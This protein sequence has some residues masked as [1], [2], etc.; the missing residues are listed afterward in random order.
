MRLATYTLA[1]LGCVLATPLAASQTTQ[2]VS[3]DITTN[4]TWTSD[5]IWQL[6]GLVYVRPN[7]TLT[8]EEGTTVVGQAQP[9]TGTG[10]LASGLVVMVDGNIEAEGTAEAPIIFTAESAL[11]GE[12]DEN[13]RGLW[14]GVIILG[15][16]TTNSTPA[17]NNVE[18]VPTSNDTRFGCQDGVS[19]F[20]CDEGDDSGT[21]RYVSIRHGGFGFEQDSEINGL[22]MGAVGSGTTIEYVEVFANS[23]DAFEWFGG[24]V[25]SKYLAGAF[26]GDD[27]FDTDRGFRGKI[28]FGFSINNPGNDAGRCLENDGGTSALGGEDATPF[29]NPIYSN[30][31]CFGAGEDADDSVLGE[32]SN[33]AALQLRDNTG[34]KIF[35]SIFANYP[36]SAINIEALS[37][38]AEDTENRLDDN[39][40]TDDLSIRNNYFF[41]FDAGDTFAAIIDDDDDNSATRQQEIESVLGAANTIGDPGIVSYGFENFDPRPT[42]TA[43]AASAADFSF[44]ALND[45]NDDDFFTEVDY[46]GAFAPIGTD[47]GDDQ[48]DRDDAVWLSE[49]TALD[50]MGYLDFRA[51]PNEGGPVAEALAL[52]VGPN[53]TAGDAT[54][55]FA[56]DRAQDARLALYDVLGREVAVVADGTFGAG[57]QTARLSTESLPA[58][59]YVLRLQAE[60]AATSVQ[61]SVVR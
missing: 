35:N 58:G 45:D 24:T 29:S 3:D 21:L 43:A 50:M 46:I 41:A 53:P 56:L 31:T 60:G 33:S 27:T 57:E 34:G 59:V 36:G 18:G 44:D 7:V 11:V 1:A 47:D 17:I 2:V 37:G 52:S 20:E 19:G 51:T 6:D 23:D 22:T 61:I 32:D 54:V 26:N 25:E 42:A 8:I 48:T 30:L 13:D 4:T 12:L 15:R 28:Q 10:D 9:S 38:D 55:R 16:S 14:G 49:W 39:E 5:T 40:A